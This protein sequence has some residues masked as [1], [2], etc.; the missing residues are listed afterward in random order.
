MAVILQMLCLHGTPTTILTPGAPEA[1]SP[2]KDIQ[3]LRDSFE[4]VLEELGI[5]LVVLID[6]LDRCL[7]ETTISTPEAIRLFL[8]LQNTALVI[9]ADNEM[10]KHA[11][12]AGDSGFRGSLALH[13]C[14][15]LLKKQYSWLVYA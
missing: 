9:A 7:P 2:A 3:A 6:D 10:I 1:K 11:E 12:C 8:F 14:S 5:A 15:S 13:C 4:E